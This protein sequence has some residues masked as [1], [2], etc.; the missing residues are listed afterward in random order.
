MLA[1]VVQK[2]Y[3]KIPKC[4]N[5]ADIL[6]LRIDLI[7]DIDLKWTEKFLKKVEKPWILT[8]R[9][10]SQGGSFEGSETLRFK[11]I[12]EYLALSPTYLD[13]EYDVDLSLVKKLKKNY[14]NLKF[15]RSFHDFKKTPNNIEE[16]ISSKYHPFFE[17]HKFAFRTNSMLDTLNLMSYLKKN[18]RQGVSLIP[19]GKYGHPLRICGRILKNAICY[20]SANDSSKIASQLS[21]KELVSIYNYQKLNYR[22][23][24]Y[25]LIGKKISHS[26]GHLF[27]NFFFSKYKINAVYIKIPLCKKDLGSFFELASSLPV[28]GLSVTTPFKMSLKPYLPCAN[29]PVNT[30][31]KRK[32][33]WQSKNTDGIGAFTVLKDSLEK[34]QKILILGAGPTALAIFEALKGS[35]IFDAY[36]RNY[37]RTILIYPK[38]VK[39]IKDFNKINFSNYDLVINAASYKAGFF[40][41]IACKR[42]ERKL[43]FFDVNYQEDSKKVKNP[44]IEKI[45]GKEL[46]FS[47]AI[48]QQMF[49][50]KKKYLFE[51]ASEFK[52]MW[53]K[54]LRQP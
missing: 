31:K 7:K 18:N 30:L 16:F 37:Q 35:C 12:S 39:V 32:N 6:E 11:L 41:K 45:D 27:H 15:I 52:R 4:F 53:M 8:V 17:I 46:F 34:K 20:A 2:K 54:D 36:S 21:V 24:I 48:Y 49:W 9:K 42:L 40:E 3:L 26:I 43:L 47:Q 38:T 14:P 33:N 22:T 13:I 25:A 51:T 5:Y 23:K 10:Q 1:V 50:N 19:M 44:F 29:G 28:A